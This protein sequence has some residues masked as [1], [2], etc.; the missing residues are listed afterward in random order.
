AVENVVFV[1]ANHELVDG[2]A[3]AKS[4]VASED[5][6]KVSR[7]DGKADLVAE[8]ERRGLLAEEG[9]VGVEV[10]DG[11]GEDASP[12]DAVYGAELVGRV[13]LGVGEEGFDN[14]LL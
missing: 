5:V 14:V 4:E 7:G 8:L 6:A 9:E 11:L 1:G 12:V 13:D 3:H 2:E 10:V